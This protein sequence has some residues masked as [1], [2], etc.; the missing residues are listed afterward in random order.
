LKAFSIPDENVC[1]FFYKEKTSS[2]TIC[3]CLILN[4]LHR[5]WIMTRQIRKRHEIN[6][7]G[8]FLIFPGRPWPLFTKIAPH[9][10]LPDT[11]PQ[12]IFFSNF[13]FKR[14]L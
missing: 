10:V 6:E 2:A 13:F 9:I 3:I 5:S 11:P 14:F 7:N 8:A 12:H 4:S 1:N